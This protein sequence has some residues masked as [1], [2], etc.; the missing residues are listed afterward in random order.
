MSD[1]IKLFVGCS[2]NGEDAESLA[3]LEYSAK[4]NSSKPVDIVWMKMSPS[5]DTFWDGWDTSEWATPFSGYRFGIPAYCGFEGQA[6]YMDSDMMI[7][8]DLAELWD[9]PFEPGKIVQSKGGW[10]FCVCKWDCAAAQNHILP[11]DRLMF[12]PNAHQRMFAA[13]GNSPELVQVFDR[14]WNNFD[15]END[16]LE[17]IKILHYTSMNHQPHLKYALPRLESSGQNHWFDGEVI[18]HWRQDVVDLFDDLYNRS[19][20]NDYDVSDYVPDTI[21]NFDKQSQKGYINAHQFVK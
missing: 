16:P 21:I 13:L 18:P 3:V 14:Q 10:R 12:L 17:D 9:A 4:K 6:I 11:L 20:E 5:K 19:I 1:T 2:P 7:L 8:G 15:G